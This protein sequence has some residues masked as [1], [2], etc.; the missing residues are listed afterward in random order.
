MTTV[1][2]QH[3]PLRRAFNT[4]S[5]AAPPSAAE[6]ADSSLYYRRFDDILQM[7]CK[8]VNDTVVPDGLVPTLLVYGSLQRP[9]ASLRDPHPT[10]FARAR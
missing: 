1:E 2:R 6:Q 3:G 10:M 8:A 4:I 5:K 7:D 9:G